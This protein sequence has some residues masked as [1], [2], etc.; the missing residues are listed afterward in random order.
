[1]HE[2]LHNVRLS[3][4]A[5]GWFIAVALTGLEI[6][7]LASLDL[8]RAGAPVEG[9]W[10]AIAIAVGFLVSSF[11][12]GTR[13]AAAPVVNGLLMALF[14]VVA[15]IAL[16]LF[17]GEPT[18]VTAWDTLPLGSAIVLLAIQAVAS[19]LGARAGVRWST[20]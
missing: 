5:F 9:A 7:V 4:V 15:W 16:N 19:V 10:V 18:G 20:R 2:H 8:V 6:V 11:Y 12:M 1:M 14:S 3:W 17:L 13:V